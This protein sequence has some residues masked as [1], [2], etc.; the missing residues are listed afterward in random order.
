M[1]LLP[2]LRTGSGE[3]RFV[4]SAAFTL[5]EM[6]IASSLLT[7][8][9]VG[10]I[11]ANIFGMRLYEITC[12]K[13]GASNEA[14]QAISKMT[15]EVKSCKILQV[16]SG[17]VNSFALDTNGILQGSALQIFPSTNTNFWIRYYWDTSDR[18]LKRTTATNGGV[19]YLVVANAISNNLVFTVEDHLG[20]TVTNPQNN[21]V[22]GMLLQFYQLAYP[23]VNI[24]GPV[25]EYY[26][27]RTKITRRVLE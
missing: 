20:N 4:R 15:D 9:L 10:I 22:V 14:R 13:L 8:V 11:S 19:T 26:Q 7:M 2:S 21:R 27:L 5:T 3:R 25:F 23:V 24:P 18:R 12:L 1:R 16:G 6:M 17:T